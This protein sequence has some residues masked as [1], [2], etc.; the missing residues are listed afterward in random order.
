MIAFLVNYNDRHLRSILTLTPE[1]IEWLNIM[2]ERET[3]RYAPLSDA[4]L[5]AACA[6]E[7]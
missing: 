2:A 7:C 1:V 4:E 6:A 3:A 5:A